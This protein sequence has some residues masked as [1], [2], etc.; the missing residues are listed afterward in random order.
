MSTVVT[1]HLYP[2]KSLGGI[3]VDTAYVERRG[4]RDDRRMMLVDPTG[5]FQTQRT[6]AKLALF[7]L[8][9]TASGFLVTAPNGETLEIG[10]ETADEVPVKVW[11]S[12]LV[13][14][15]VSTEADQWFSDHLQ[16]PVSLVRMPDSVTRPTHPDYSRPGDHVSFADGFPILMISEE[17]LADLNSRLAVPLP[18]NR[19]RPNIVVR[20]MEPYAEDDLGEFR[21]GNCRMRSVK[22]CGRCRVTTIDQETA[23]IGQEPLRTLATYRQE[24]NAVMFGANIIP[25]DEGLIRV[26]DLVQ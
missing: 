3:E 6:K 4:L 14:R 24:G 16:E 18:M 5:L 9:L 10:P 26:G 19:F 1:I 17:S 11:N 25:D 21:I 12:E 2:I 20:G 8:S 7:R 13:A 15:R 23:E 22:K